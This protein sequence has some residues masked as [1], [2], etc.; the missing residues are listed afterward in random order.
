MN[1]TENVNLGGYSFKVE[2]D[3]YHALDEYLKAIRATYNNDE[4]AD[5]I[6]Q[7]I[8]VRMAELLME[9]CSYSTKAPDANNSVVV[10]LAMVQNL[11]K[12]IGEPETLAEEEQE[13]LNEYKDKG[14]KKE[15]KKDWRKAR[16]YRNIEDR[17]FGGICSGLA[18]YFN[19]DVAFIRILFV[20]F[21]LIGIFTNAHALFG[22]SVVAYIILWIAV[23]AARTVEQKC[24]MK[25]KPLNLNEFK[26]QG[27]SNFTEL[28]SEVRTAPAIKTIGKVGESL[29]GMISLILGLGITFGAVSTLLV[30]VIV[31][32]T[33][34]DTYITGE[35]DAYSTA[36]NEAFLIRSLLNTSVFW[37]FVSAIVGILGILFIYGGVKLLFK[38]KAPAWKPGLI[39]FIAW[40]IT[41]LAFA[42]WIVKTVLPFTC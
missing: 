1:T 25:G 27:A 37:W 23:P 8:E 5:D 15:E 35:F 41:V 29:I 24:E 6:L 17:A 32:T 14:K 12:R 39:M 30:P 16:L 7:D 4:Y 28:E 10:T 3:A 20:V 42:L 36:I 34:F 33:F 13:T 11:K 40:I 9:Q 19:T 31:P 2:T 18:A 22:F 38:L 26:A 21:T